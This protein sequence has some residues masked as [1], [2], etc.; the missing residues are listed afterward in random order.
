MQVNVE[1]YDQRE[2]SF[3][4]VDRVVLEGSSYVIYGD[5]NIVVAVFA[6]NDVKLLTQQ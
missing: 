5:A 3:L 2:Y 6:K 4:A 1:L